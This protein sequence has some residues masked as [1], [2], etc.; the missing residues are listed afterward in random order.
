MCLSPLAFTPDKQ[1]ELATK[2]AED[3]TKSRDANGESEH[4]QVEEMK[5]G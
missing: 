3:S 1:P 4:Q 2:R 5:G